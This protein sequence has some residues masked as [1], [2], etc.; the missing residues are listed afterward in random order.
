MCSALPGSHASRFSMDTKTWPER[1]AG[2]VAVVTGGGDGL[3]FAIAQRLIAEG[4][5]VWL[6]DRDDARVK[7]AA[8]RLGPRAFAAALDIADEPAVKAGFEAVTA[9]HGRL[10]VMVNSAGIVGPNNK[11]ITETPTDGYEQVLRVNLFGTF[12]VCK[13]A[14]LQMQPRNYGRV[15][16]I[17]SIAGK[18]GNAGMCAYSSAKAGVI[19]LAKSVGKEF[20]ETGIT[21]N[22]LAP[23]VIRTAMV[24]GMDP[25]QVKYMTDKIPMKRCGALDEVASLAAWIVSPEASFNTGF[26]FD[27]T[28][29]RAVY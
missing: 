21:I 26:T 8:S 28:G 1:F 20:A 9:Q 2:Q 13:H 29:G 15:L 6:F 14:L 25:A 10:D 19:G 5:T 24:E 18:E 27:L 16:L 22:A 17:A 12:L 23:A 11:K 3:G 4:A 7:A